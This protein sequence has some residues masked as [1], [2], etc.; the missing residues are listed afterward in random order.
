MAL[1][2]LFYLAV[3]FPRLEK[4]IR[5]AAKRG[6]KNKMIQALFNLTYAWRY[7]KTYKMPFFELIKRAWLWKDNY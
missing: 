3:K 5:W 7:S 6:H 1:Q 2:K 4:F